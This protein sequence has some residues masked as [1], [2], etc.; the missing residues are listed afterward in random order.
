MGKHQNMYG[1]KAHPLDEMLP[2]GFDK[3]VV[4]D[5]FANTRSMKL[6]VLAA[7][8]SN[9]GGIGRSVSELARAKN[10][11]TDSEPASETIAFGGS[12]S[13]DEAD[14]L[15]HMHD[16]DHDHRHE[17]ADDHDHDHMHDHGDDHVEETPENFAEAR[18]TKGGGRNKT[19]DTDGSTDSGGGRGKGKK[20]DN[21]DTG[22][23]DDQ[24][25]PEPEAEADPAPAPTPVP[26]PEPEEPAPTPVAD[27]PDEFGWL[28]SST[29][30]SGGDT[31]DGFNVELVF[32]GGSWTSSQKDAAAAQA[33]IL[34]DI[35]IGDLPNYGD[36]DD[37]RIQ[38]YNE[39]I[40]GAN[41]VWGEGGWIKLRSDGMV[42]EG[43]V[44]VDVND[45]GSA[46]SRDMMDELFMHEM[47]H[48]I[49]FGT[50]WNR[51]G[52]ISNGTFIGATA[53][54]V[55]GSA[56]P[57]NGNGHLDESVGNEMGTTFISNG[58]EDITDLT[59]AILEDMGFETVYDS[60][61]SFV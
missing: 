40:D 49:G 13:T 19:T 9:E 41:G 16:H 7:K 43:G 61:S 2:D 15:A 26:Q 8:E 55:Y 42:A 37:V 29:Y 27:S 38:M 20:K 30:L 3:E 52:L 51:D 12:L 39:N 34:S 60:N 4:A 56:V 45:I 48:A 6:D 46:E 47:L 28:N 57:L 11:D 25:A 22:S 32:Y 53:V 5:F 17:D 50:T 24:P 35:I 14:M 23:T 59:L 58:A 33:E 18:G 36:I 1:R 54:D 31:P 21:T 10:D 44:R